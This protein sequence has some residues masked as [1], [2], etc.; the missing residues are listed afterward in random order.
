M[1]S[2]FKSFLGIF[3][4]LMLCCTGIGLVE[5][6]IEARGADSYLSRVVSQIEAGHYSSRVISD[7]KTDAT[8]RGYELKVDIHKNDTGECC[9]IAS[10]T[11]RYN[12][13][14]LGLSQKHVALADIR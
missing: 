11:Y 13:P 6:S 2:I 14:L 3:F 8:S 4:L 7:C 9:G 1:E 10:L 5:A 12:V